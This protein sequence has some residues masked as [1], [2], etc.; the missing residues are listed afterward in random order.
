M[1]GG[2]MES[3]NNSRGGGGGGEMKRCG[4]QMPL[5]YPRYTRAEYEVMAEWKLD[6]LLAQYGLHPHVSGDVEHKRKFAMG[7]FLWTY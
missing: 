6:C 1:S 2:G 5:H 4:F 7:A 3:I